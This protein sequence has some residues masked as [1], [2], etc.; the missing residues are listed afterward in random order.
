[1]ITLS[2][3]DITTKNPERFKRYHN[4]FK[5][6]REKIIAVEEK[7]HLRN[8]QPPI[9]GEVIMKCFNLK[10]S[11]EIGLIKEAI[12]EAILE[13]EIPNEQKAAFEKMK[14]EGKKRGLIFHEK[15]I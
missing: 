7:D 15:T 9:S 8:F 2:E 5:I 14:T 13:G 10:P 1:M 12:K 6:V 3:A 11:R 4:N